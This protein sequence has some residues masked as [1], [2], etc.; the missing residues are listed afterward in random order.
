MKRLLILLLILCITS[1][2]LPVSAAGN[3]T[4]Y[5]LSQQGST[6][7]MSQQD[8]ELAFWEA[9]DVTTGQSHTGG[10]LTLCNDSDRPVDFVL[11]SVSLPYDNEAALAY[12]DAVTLTVKQDGKVVYR[13]SFTHLMD[14]ERR[15]IRLSDVLPGEQAQLT[16]AISCA[17]TYTGGIPAYNSLVWTF[18]PE[19][20]GTT[21]TTA[22]DPLVND[23]APTTNWKQIAQVAGTVA[24]VMAAAG[25]CVWITRKIRK[26]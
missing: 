6:F 22:P 3:E 21:T 7:T 4:L 13:D 23:S 17:Y 14:A 26:K 12:L 5:V 11:T 8:G 19:L 24:L 20:K 18:T 15:E 1:V 9:P 2:A 10:V 25:V 16:F